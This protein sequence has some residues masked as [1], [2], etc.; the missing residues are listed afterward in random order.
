MTLKDLKKLTEQGECSTLEFKKKANY[1]EKIVK[2]L[3]AFANTNG[4]RLLL[5]VDDNGALSGTRDIEG[6]AFILEKAIQE[7][8]RPKIN[9]S[10]EYIHLTEKKGIAIFQVQESQKKP[11][12]VR[13]N[14]NTRKGTAYVRFRDESIQA[15]RE[16]RE[17]IQ[18]KLKNKDIQFTYG[19]KEKTVVNH[20]DA[21][22]K[23]TLTEFSQITKTP[24][25]IASK[26][27]IRLVLA[28]V[29]DIIPNPKGDYFILKKEAYES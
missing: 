11:H 5:G 28:N 22:E 10:V 23:I 9:Y 2:E 24:K 3:V 20:L 1:P 27:L 6:E 18:R 14:P 25:F 26:T 4:G 13:E 29:L 15:S 12:F 21:H 16:V 17:I 19:D 7:L 8:I